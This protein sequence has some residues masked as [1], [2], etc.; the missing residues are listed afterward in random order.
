MDDVKK[1]IVVGYCI[2]IILSILIVP[3]KIDWHSEMYSTKISKGYSF[4]LSPPVPAATIDFSKIFLEFVL[5]TAGAGI[6]YVMRDKIFK[7]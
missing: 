6:I 4:V 3:W 7:K 2:A 1:K 5:I